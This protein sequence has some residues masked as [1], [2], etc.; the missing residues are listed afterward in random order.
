MASAILNLD[1]SK[2]ALVAAIEGEAGKT[3]LGENAK[4]LKTAVDAGFVESF[5]DLL[6]VGRETRPL[7]DAMAFTARP[8]I[9]GVTWNHKACLEILKLC[10]I[11]LKNGSRW[12][13]PAELSQEEKILF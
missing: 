1:L 2:I 11:P 12:R 7:A 4:V 13:V 9:E 8:F 3:M 5:Q 6:L 10:N